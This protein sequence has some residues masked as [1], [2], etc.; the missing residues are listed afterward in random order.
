MPHIFFL[1][2]TYHYSSLFAVK[3]HPPRLPSWGGGG[4]G[5]EREVEEE[6]EGLKLL[7]QPNY[8]GLNSVQWT[9]R[10]FLPFFL[11]NNLTHPMTPTL[12]PATTL[13]LTLSALAL[14]P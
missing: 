5:R 6:M 12:T 7:R 13:A 9:P 11:H 14:T 2:G 8:V 1:E 3:K 4:G 10:A